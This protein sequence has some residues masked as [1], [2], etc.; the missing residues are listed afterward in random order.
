M[1]APL[2]FLIFI[3]DLP[4]SVSVGIVLFASDCTLYHEISSM[5]E[6]DIFNNAIQLLA[7]WCYMWQ[8]SFSTNRVEPAYN[9]LLCILNSFKI[10]L[11]ILDI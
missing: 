4:R 7:D 9:E 5:E 11:K 10:P 8:I 6:R 1:L 2:L 3:N